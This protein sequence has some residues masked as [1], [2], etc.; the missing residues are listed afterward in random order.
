MEIPEYLKSVAAS[1]PAWL[2]STPGSGV[3]LSSRVRLA[4]N[5]AGKAFPHRMDYDDRLALWDEIGGVLAGLEAL[6]ESVSLE[7]PGLSAISKQILF[8]RHLISREHL[9]MGHGSGVVLDKDEFLA[10]M[11]N[12]EDHLRLQ[13][14]RPGLEIDKAWE[15]IDGLD[16]DIEQQVDFAFSPAYG[17][18]T[19]CPTNVGT[20]LR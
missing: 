10:V 2:R 8:E 17:Y 14:F 13:S 20:G 16:S 5:L 7:M 6:G 4:R 12:E 15:R 3:V 9:L 1:P 19:C 18:L 11:V